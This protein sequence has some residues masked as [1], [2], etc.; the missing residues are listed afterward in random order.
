MAW[1]T[2]ITA[3]NVLYSL[4]TGPLD[5]IDQSIL[6]PAAGAVTMSQLVF[7]NATASPDVI[8]LAATGLA[9]TLDSTLINAYLCS[10]KN[11]QTQSQALN[12]LVTILVNGQSTV[13][14]LSDA[15]NGFYQFIS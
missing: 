5:Q 9:T 2:N 1:T 3:C 11:S 12:G 15:I 14:N 10:Y 4:L 6:F 7:F 13:E 8:K